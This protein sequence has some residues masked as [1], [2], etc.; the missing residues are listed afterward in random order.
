[1]LNNEAYYDEFSNW[2][3][4][5]RHHG[6][7]VLIDDLETDLILPA[8]SNN[9]VLEI[10]CGTGLILKRVS[11]VAKSAVGIDLSSGMLQTAVKRGLNVA[12]A[13]A[14]ALPF[15]DESFDTVY[16]FK[17][18]SHIND[19]QQALNEC[20]R[21]TRPGGRLFLEFYNRNSLRYMIKRITRPQAI[22]ETV[23]E[24]SVYTRWY[25]M[26]ELKQL[27]PDNLKHVGTA[28]VRVVTPVASVHRIP[29]VRT[30]MR[31]AEYLARDSKL[32][33]YGGFLVLI[34]QKSA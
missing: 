30:I 21:V 22:S 27:L 3:E 4:R 25:D 10:G 31:Q 13:T 33:P 29:I 6:Y 19:I 23:R 11:P 17:V 14:T 26:S 9:D 1:M 8:C 16:S 28:G 32:A 20:A 2:Y 34:L 12:Q 7:H 24:S 5:E 15:A 18:L